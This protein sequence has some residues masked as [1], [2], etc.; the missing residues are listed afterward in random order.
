MGCPQIGQSSASGGIPPIPSAR[1]QVAQHFRI[2][3][4]SSV[5]QSQL[6]NSVLKFSLLEH[7]VNF[8]Q[9]FCDKVASA[10]L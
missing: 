3:Q 2:L 10:F 4:K 8:P 6:K 7:R 9:M 5:Q 1:A